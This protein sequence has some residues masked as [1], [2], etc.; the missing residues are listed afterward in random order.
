MNRI[1]SSQGGGF[2]NKLSMTITEIKQR[3]HNYFEVADAK[4]IK[5]LYIIMEKEIER[6]ESISKEK[7]TIKKN[8][9]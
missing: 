2:V 9:K 8:K 6:T 3:L 5:A 1:T 4:K 7:N